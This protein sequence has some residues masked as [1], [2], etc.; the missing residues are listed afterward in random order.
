MTPRTDS[1]RVANPHSEHV[2]CCLVCGRPI[3]PCKSRH[4][5]G[6]M[7]SDDR[8]ELGDDGHRAALAFA[9]IDGAS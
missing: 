3:E 8:R 7:H 1:R 5:G 9:S 4:G 2:V 6:F